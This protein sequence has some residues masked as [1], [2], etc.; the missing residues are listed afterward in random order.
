[1]FYC[2]RA[3]E[4][5]RQRNVVVSRFFWAAGSFKTRRS[6]PF[7][8]P[9][10]K[11]V[12]KL[13]LHANKYEPNGFSKRPKSGQ[14]KKFAEIIIANQL[15]TKARQKFLMIFLAGMKAKST[16]AFLLKN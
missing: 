16:F 12:L 4:G 11:N 9:F 15:V 8:H 7:P 10:D 3:I 2:Y 1:V 5:F 13:G 14:I 6:H